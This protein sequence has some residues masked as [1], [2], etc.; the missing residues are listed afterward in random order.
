[1]ILINGNIVPSSM[2]NKILEEL[3]SRLN[4]TLATQSLNPYWVIDACDKLS[5]KLANGDYHHLISSLPIDQNLVKEQ[6]HTV[7]H[8]L[9]KES[10]LCKL[11]TELGPKPFEP[12]TIVPPFEKKA[13]I[14][15][16]YPL[17]VLFHIAA[18]NVDG[19]PA[20]SVVEGLL[21]G[22]INILKLP[23]ADQDLSITLLAELITAEP[24]LKDYI[25]VFDTPSTDLEAMKYMAKLSDGVVVWGGDLAVAAIRKMVAPGTKLIEWGHKLGFAYIVPN[26]ITASALTAL[27]QHIFRTKQL[28]CSSCQTIYIDTENMKE[29]YDF[30]ETFLPLMEQAALKYP[31]NDIGAVA[32][33][34]LQVY[35]AELENLFSTSRTFKGESTS[36]IAKIDNTLELSFMFGNCLVKPLPRHQLL[37]TLRQSKPYLQT[38]GLLCLAEDY[39]TLSN[40]LLR[41]GVVRVKELG[42][43][44]GMTCTDAHDGDYPLRRYTKITE[45]D[46]MDFN[47]LTFNK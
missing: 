21:A 3:P 36:L 41:A 5:K 27:A 46:A 26:A 45:C 30:C 19:L 33:S 18:G 13:I 4:Q 31:I 14:K 39:P 40:L 22:N 43:M 28:L 42:E 29:V 34:T 11:H 23:Q 9:K 24:R 47:I 35:N 8:M 7:I 44:S 25:Y 15:H 37:E 10:L 1:M 38:A 32:Q 17:G 16:T 6:L 20:Y 12:E 2:Q